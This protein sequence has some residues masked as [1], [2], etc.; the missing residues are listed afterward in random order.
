MKQ[1]KLWLVIASCVFIFVACQRTST[2]DGHS[3]GQHDGTQVNA[4]G[5]FGTWPPQPASMEKIGIVAGNFAPQSL[6]NMQDAEIEAAVMSNVDVI[7]A[8]GNDYTLLDT[9]IARDKGGNLRPEVI[10]FSYSNNVTVVASIKQDNSVRHEV[11]AADDYQFPEGAEDIRRAKTLA[12]AALVDQGFADAATLN[13]HAMLTFPRRDA[14]KSFHNVRM[15]YVTVGQ[16][17]GSLPDYAAW[18]D[19]TNSQVVESGPIKGYE[20]E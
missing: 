1:L 19:L 17:N 11:F 15:I 4:S 14:E 16:G 12:R 2:T 10:F 3:H 9:N 5:S 6:R 13:A 18:V 7:A 20:G 8:L